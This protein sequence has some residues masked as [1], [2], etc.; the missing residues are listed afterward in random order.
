[1][2]NESPEWLRELTAALRSRIES[3]ETVPRAISVG[4]V[5]EVGDGIA[6]ASGLAGAR[7][8]Q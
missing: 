5:I 1:M 8:M 3:F 7:S 2:A 6:R 4:E